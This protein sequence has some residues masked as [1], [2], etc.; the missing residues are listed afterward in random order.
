MFEAQ[1]RSD[2]Q[3]YR[4]DDVNSILRAA[5]LHGFEQFDDGLDDGHQRSLVC[6]G[7]Y[8]PGPQ[9]VVVLRGKRADKI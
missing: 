8:E 3:R 4:A 7:Y 1:S 2:D 9:I 6:G 5:L